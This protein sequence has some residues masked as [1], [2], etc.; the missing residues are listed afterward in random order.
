MRHRLL[1]L[2]VCILV[3]LSSVARAQDCADPPPIF[4]EQKKVD[5]EGAIGKFLKL[6]GLNIRFDISKEKR[7]I[8]SAFPNADQTV[9]ALTTIHNVCSL[10]K[11]S[12]QIPDREKIE[13][14]VSLQTQFFS[15]RPAGPE[16]ISSTAPPRRDIA[17]TSPEDRPGRGKRS[18]ITAPIV[19]IQMREGSSP[20]AR[21]NI[22]WADIYLNPL[23]LVITEKNKYFVLVG[24]A[25]SEANGRKQL[26][27]LKSRYP[28]Y[29][30]ELYAPYGSNR[31]YGI[32]IASWVSRERANE[33]LAVARNIDVSSF[34]WACRSTGE[35]C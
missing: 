34:I 35:E 29:D 19:L 33:A 27:E 20:S 8:F 5:T 30:F 28:N 18:Q 12:T 25:S 23:P 14:L 1:P 7:S 17:P 9:V 3:S 26:S 2:S 31:S 16:P 22:S 15:A 10:L 11:E 24:S 6:V 21:R 4:D 32:M 13:I